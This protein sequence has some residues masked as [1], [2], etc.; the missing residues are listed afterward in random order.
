MY[1]ENDEVT[2]DVENERG[3]QE[4][5]EDD[6][7]EM[8]DEAEIADNDAATKGEKKMFNIIV[9]NGKNN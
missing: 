6:D 4:T 7:E 3:E 2:N 8:K 1:S 5:N 9:S